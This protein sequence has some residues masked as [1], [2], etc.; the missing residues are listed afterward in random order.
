MF[1]RDLDFKKNPTVCKVYNKKEVFMNIF[2]FRTSNRRQNTNIFSLSRPSFLLLA[3]GL[4]A[5]LCQ[6]AMILLHTQI[7]S[8]A[9]LSPL[10]ALR[11]APMLEHS[12]MSLV[13]LAVGTYLTERTCRELER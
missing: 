5:V 2:P 10:L 6:L 11:F 12:L 3:Y 8:E 1:L 13:I 7:H 4:F 9:V